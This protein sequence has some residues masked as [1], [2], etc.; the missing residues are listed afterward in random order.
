MRFQLTLGYQ[1]PTV[2]NISQDSKTTHLSFKELF[3]QEFGI[4][5]PISDRQRGNLN[6]PYTMEIWIIPP[7]AC[8]QRYCILQTQLQ[9]KT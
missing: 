2:R 7:S 1:H 5:F 8:K 6:C 4:Q 3:T 9:I